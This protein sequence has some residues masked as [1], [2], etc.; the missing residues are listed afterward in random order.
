MQDTD[1]D[2]L[3]DFINDKVNIP[4]LT[5]AQEKALFK[6]ILGLIIDL[7]VKKLKRD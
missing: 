2:E 3:T 5:E 1:I 7:V 6:L 4:L